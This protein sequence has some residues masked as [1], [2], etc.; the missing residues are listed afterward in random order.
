MEFRGP[1]PG[2]EPVEAGVESIVLML[3]RAR[4]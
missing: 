2:S 4:L 3:E 1:V